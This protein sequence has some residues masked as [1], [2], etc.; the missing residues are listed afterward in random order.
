MKGFIRTFK[1]SAIV[2]GV[3][4]VLG[5]IVDLIGIVD[6]LSNRNSLLIRLLRYPLPLW[7]VFLLVLGLASALVLALFGSGRTT[8]SKDRGWIL[9]KGAFYWKLQV[10]LV[11]ARK[12]VLIVGLEKE[13]IFPLVIS[14]VVARA[15]EV[16]IDVI[17]YSSYH[18][19][20]HLLE[21]LG[22][23]IYHVDP[24]MT[25]LPI[26]GALVDPNQILF[27]CA[28]LHNPREKE[29]VYAKYYFGSADHYVIR[30]T[31]QQSSDMIE[32]ASKHS[33]ASTDNEPKFVPE[34]VPI[35]EQELLAR[36][37]NVRFYGSATI[38]FEDVEVQEVYPVTDHVLRF[39]ISQIK[40]LFRIYKEKGWELFHPCAVTLQNGKKSIIIPPVIEE[41]GGRLY[42]AEGHSRFYVLREL[43]IKRVK[44]IVVRG[45]TQQL[46]RNPTKWRSVRVVDQQ[47]EYGV[48]E[49][50][51]H[52]ETT[53][54][55]NVW[56]ERDIY[57][58]TEITPKAT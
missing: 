10:M 22:C 38:R 37:R 41:H 36:M 28:A 1:I 3:A 55:Q 12:R 32:Q 35:D 52:I 17:Y 18:E 54:H 45:V 14:I 47:Y 15:R 40:H 5:L 16:T 33:E 48:L 34:V 51:R 4:L 56:G 9:S 21:L 53:V 19:R 8:T 20:Y 11:N 24:E 7:A 58:P 2:A 6:T 25:R 27:C 42:I 39:K 46:P 49:F 57:P 30:S 29:N 13:W 43:G 31:Y 50:A 26:E 23:S 44:A